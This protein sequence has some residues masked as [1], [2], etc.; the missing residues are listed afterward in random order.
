MSRVRVYFKNLVANW[1]GYGAN[2]IIMFFMS[3]FVVEHLGDVQYGIWSFMI[4]FTGYLGLIEI[5]TRSGVGRF[6]NYYLGKKESLKL[7]ETI[8]TGVAIFIVAGLILLIIS[9]ILS[10]FLQTLFPKIPVSLIPESR[11]ILFLLSGNIGISLLSAPFRQLLQAY[12]RF[13]L[14]NVLDLG[15]LVMRNA[16]F[17]YF[18]LEG[19]GLL[20]LGIVHTAV[21][22]LGFL[23][24][25]FLSK[26]LFPQLHFHYNLVSIDSFKELFG[27]SI[28]AFL[29][30]LSY[31]L[32]YTTD[33]IVIGIFLSPEWVTFYSIGVMLLHRSRD[34]INQATGIFEPKIMQDCAKQD[35]KNLR[36]LFYYGSNLTMGVCILVFVG[37]ICFG[38]EFICLWMGPRFEISYDIL[39]I[40]TMGSFFSVAIQIT[41]PIYAGL[42]KVK[43]RS[44]L[45]L[46]QGLTNLLLSI[47]F[48]LA[49]GM[50]IKG[51]AWGSFIPSIIWPPVIGLIAMK[52]MKFHYVRY[53]C[54]IVSRWILLGL[55]FYLLCRFL[56]D[57]IPQGNWQGFFTKVGASTIAYVILAFI[58]LPKLNE[59]HWLLATVKEKVRVSFY[60]KRAE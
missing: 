27:F 36:R 58:T 18:L 38:R 4:T 34:L 46:S 9:F 35:F 8:N 13:E 37:M 31:R 51:V 40:L 42:N 14:I 15:T 54:E 43:L 12:E 56:N 57:V 17:I 55:I 21:G 53:C 41:A 20:A 7:I 5:G 19:H 30:N 59:M 32:L 3:P 23:A 22:F 50:G 2:L 52:W 6:I 10:F 60:T 28:W 26:K 49:L 25:I 11:T 1:V 47:Y 44:L 45:T 48:V 16:L 39:F 33:T 29:G 24:T